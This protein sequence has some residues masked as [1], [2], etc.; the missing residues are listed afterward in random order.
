MAQSEFR[1]G[2]QGQKQRLND[3]R[4]WENV[5]SEDARKASPLSP[6]GS[7]QAASSD[8]GSSP[9]HNVEMTPE[10]KDAK[11]LETSRDFVEYLLEE[12]FSPYD[13]INGH[14]SDSLDDTIT[15]YIEY[16]GVP[17]S[18]FDHIIDELEGHDND[19]SRAYGKILDDATK[20]DRDT[21]KRLQSHAYKDADYPI[22]V[23]ESDP[24]LYPDWLEHMF[25]G[26]Y[27]DTYENFYDSE[28]YYFSGDLR[29]L[30]KE[31]VST[32]IGEWSD[33]VRQ[34][35]I[36]SNYLEVSSS[37]TGWMNNEAKGVIEYDAFESDSDQPFF[38]PS[39]NDGH[40]EWVQNEDGETL[41]IIAYHHDSPT[42]ETWNVRPL[43]NKEAK[44]KLGDDYDESYDL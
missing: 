3:N 25:D 19:F 38:I 28:S 30:Q 21:M 9:A 15:E 42:G 1:V 4:R 12:G 26:T 17:E 24:D 2:P 34:N 6:S 5:D 10:E 14:H 39:G 16:K 18:D 41:T 43:S 40:Y 8:F 22:A 13:V 11:Q 29:E 23:L 37:N 44:D 36:E 7:R 20:Y 31:N 27:N 32:L 33:R 35:G